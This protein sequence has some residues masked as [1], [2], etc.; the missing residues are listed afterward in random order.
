MTACK[1]SL[2]GKKAVSATLAGVLAVGMVPAAAFAATDAQAADT[3]DE[4]GIEL[5]TAGKADAVNAGKITA[6]VDAQGNA[7]DLSKAVSFVADGEAQAIVPTEITPAAGDV[8]DVNAKDENG[9]ALWQVKYGVPKN[10][11]ATT[12]PSGGDAWTSWS[13]SAPTTIGTYWAVVSATSYNADYYANGLSTVYVGAKFAVTAATLEGAVAFEKNADD[14]A[15][16]SDTTFTYDG[17]DQ[18]SKIGFELDGKA[19]DEANYDVA[20]K[21]KGAVAT[22]TAA[23]PENAG[24]YV[25]VL[26]GKTG[27]AYEGSQTE[28]LFSIGKLNL[29]EVAASIPDTMASGAPAMSSVL[30][31]GK[32]QSVSGDCDLTLVSGKNAAGQTLYTYDQKGE[33]TYTI[34]P[35]TNNNNVEG[36]ATVTVNK[37]A[38]NAVVKYDGTVVDSAY[39]WN[40]D[41]TVDLSGDDPLLFDAAKVKVYASSS[42]TAL[43]SDK[44]TVTYT[45]DK[46]NAATADDV[47]TAGNWIATVQVNAAANDYALGG[48]ATIAIKNTAGVIS[49]AS[50][51]VSYDGNVTDAISAGYDGENVLDKVAV[52]VKDAKGNILTE[53]TDYTVEVKD[54]KGN[55]VT[56]AVDAGDYTLGI[57]S[58]K[59]TLG[60]AAND[61]KVAITIAPVSISG[62]VSNPAAETYHDTDLGKVRIKGLKTYKATTIMGYTGEEIV[63]EFEYISD[64][65]AKGN[66]TWSDVPAGQFKVTKI[67]Y[68]ANAAT[69]YPKTVDAVEATGYYKVT[70]ADDAKAEKT[71]NYVINSTDVAF[72]VSDQKLFADVATTDWFADVVYKAN[73]LNYMNGYA[74]TQFFGP[75]N[76]LTRGDAAVV[77]YKMAGHK[78][79]TSHITDTE[80]V[81]SDVE[82]YV[83]FADA[84]AWAKD[85]GIITGYG[86]GTFK[87]QQNVTREEF[88]LM[89]QRYAKAKGEAA[90]GDASALAG[91]A[92]ASAVDSWAADAVAW[93]VSDKIM[94]QNTDVINPGASI[95]R[96]EVAAMAVRYQ[97]EK[98]ST[99][100][101]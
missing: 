13:D 77:L 1:D 17:T 84:V 52:V 19:I 60:A 6:A 43:K 18:S 27:T 91:Y 66:A 86:D 24:E 23:T 14:P 21:A 70:I 38:S 25:A 67:Q 87:P 56:E 101:G 89:L 42:A 85:M 53:G 81:F 65:D 39:K 12:L 41:T 7:V 88:A 35:K 3:Q 63:P 50:M 28:V 99:I 45:D 46:G 26:T 79:G 98:I 48:T 82:T 49:E 55:V 15:D 32:A 5:L 10:A 92:D 62:A 100:L 94:G 64:V 96:A 8:I 30:F 22:A 74:G 9:N 69:T 2:N 37:V 29:A 54:A 75:N 76:A 95:S 31:G 90:T 33:Y 78:T 16:V 71:E 51:Y 57:K 36:T 72:Q 59:Y 97:P 80:N 93:A 58:G 11:A 4:Q 44:Y 20:Y 68:N 47:K 73:G 61:S 34:A 83:Y 40:N